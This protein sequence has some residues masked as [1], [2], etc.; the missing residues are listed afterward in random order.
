MEKPH[1]GGHLNTTHVDAGVL[2][3]LIDRIEC[4]T[5]VDV[6]C[7]PGGM[8]E[9]ALNE[10]MH[11]VGID[12]DVSIQKP[13]ILNYDFTLGPMNV[14]RFDIGWCVEFV[15]HVEECYMSNYFTQLR[16]CDFVVMTHAPSGFSGHHHV[17]CQ[18]ED[19]WL[20]VFDGCGYDLA[21]ELTTEMRA[22]STMKR[23]FMRD[24]G[25]LFF[26]RV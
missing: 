26:K 9:L 2:E 15:E 24:T 22:A 17:N 1:L 21:E 3:F 14:G 6:G 8:V 10:G 12:G 20:R 7:G 4:E 18:D 19:Y 5:L 23:D 13:W 25:K 11:A 16:A